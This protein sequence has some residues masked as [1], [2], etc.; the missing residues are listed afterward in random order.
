MRHH[1]RAAENL[2][3][4]LTGV[5]PEVAARSAAVCAAPAAAGR[6]YPRYR[7]RIR[8]RSIKQRAA[9]G[10]S[11]TAALHRKVTATSGRT[12]PKTWFERRVIEQTAP[13]LDIPETR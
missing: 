7:S 1:A 5:R 12:P 3:I 10:L 4:S 6:G 9:A 13:Q 2:S 8:C 11:G